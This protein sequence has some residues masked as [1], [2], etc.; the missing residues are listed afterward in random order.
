MIGHID[1][2]S[3][4]TINNFLRLGESGKPNEAL[5]LEKNAD[6]SQRLSTG[7]SLK[8]R[9]IVYFSGVCFL[10]NMACIKARLAGINNAKENAVECF[11]RLL[12]ALDG[13]NARDK[14][15]D[16]FKYNKYFI[17]ANY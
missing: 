14:I 3:G 13:E 7:L 8:D 17:L 9:F 4:F 15:E 2:V 11:T 6:G 10:K 12:V 16:H 1:S 5:M